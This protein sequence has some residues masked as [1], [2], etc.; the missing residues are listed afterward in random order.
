MIVSDE[1][2]KLVFNKDDDV[3]KFILNNNGIKKE[4]ELRPFHFFLNACLNIRKFSLSLAIYGGESPDF[5]LEIDPELNIGLEHTRATNEKYKMDDSESERCPPGTRIEIPYY[6]DSP[7]P[8]KK[9]CI[10][11][12]RPGEKLT[13]GGW[14]DY[15]EEKAWSDTVLGIIAKKIESLN[16]TDFKK[17]SKNELLIDGTNLFYSSKGMQT[18]IDMLINKY[19]AKT[20]DKPLLYDKYHI[21]M[22]NNLIYDVFG[23][24][25]I[26]ENKI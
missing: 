25:I 1:Y 12:K 15:G 5:L 20:F 24:K 4:Y 13:H 2:K 11:I 10:A 21:I 16:K 7:P 8:P 14:G 3:E 22:G 18:S 9:S 19:S 17:F 6:S 23:D 26:V